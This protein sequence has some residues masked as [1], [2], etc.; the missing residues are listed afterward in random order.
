M[1]NENIK[2]HDFRNHNQT[3]ETEPTSKFSSFE[4]VSNKFKSEKKAKI[5]ETRGI[6]DAQTFKTRQEREKKKKAEAIKKRKLAAKMAKTPRSK[7]KG[8][9]V[10]TASFKAQSNRTTLGGVKI[11][12]KNINTG[13]V[14]N[15]DYIRVDDKL[16]DNVQASL[17]YIIMGSTSSGE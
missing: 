14:E 7:Q 11:S 10:E 5:D 9:C 4:D 1:S 15:F 2:S 17:K 12:C 13:R 3:L 8:F 6:R 16:S